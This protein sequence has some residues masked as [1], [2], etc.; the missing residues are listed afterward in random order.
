MI[1]RLHLLCGW[2]VSTWVLVHSR[3]A[4]GAR[5]LLVDRH[6]VICRDKEGPSLLHR[7]REL[8]WERRATEAEMGS[9]ER[10]RGLG[11]GELEKGQSISSLQPPGQP[12][13]L[14]S[15]I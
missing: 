14:D 6:V 15:V 11:D 5:T 10:R 4:S 1:G 3:E 9:Q 12:G 8:M 2:E 7:P 13:L